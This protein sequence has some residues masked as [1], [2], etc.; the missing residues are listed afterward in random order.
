MKVWAAWTGLILFCIG[1][2][3]LPLCAQEGAA[4]Y[5]K[6]CAGCHEAG[7]ESRAPG[8]DALKQLSPERILV[9]LESGVMYRQGLQRIPAERRAIAAFLSEKPLG[10]EPLTPMPQ[11]AFCDRSGSGFRDPSAGPAW[12]GWGASLTNT[13]F[14]PAE[15][16]G[17]SSEEVPRLKL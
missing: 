10:S 13:R 6:H 16:A 5:Q 2:A 8:R 9:V 17:I 15:A 4:L 3:G 7:G 1:F 12:N 14:Q 11:S